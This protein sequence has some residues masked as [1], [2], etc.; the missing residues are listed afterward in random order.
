MQQQLQR[1]LAAV[2]GLQL[3][4]GRGL[5]LGLRLLAVQEVCVGAQP[6]GYDGHPK[7]DVMQKPAQQARHLQP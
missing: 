2:R 6:S 4:L 1:L 3:R 7:G 5:R